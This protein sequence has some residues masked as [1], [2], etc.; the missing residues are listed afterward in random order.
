MTVIDQIKVLNNK[1][2]LNQAQYD[3]D[4]LTAK[5]S[6]LS[7]SELRK[8]VYLTG[9][10][11]GYRLSVLE[12]TNFNYSPLGKVFN[13]RLDDKDDKKEGLLKRF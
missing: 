11:L 9:E 10:D 1:I 4:R 8:Y 5:I 13:K 3:L 2:K 7:C 6:A 12:Q